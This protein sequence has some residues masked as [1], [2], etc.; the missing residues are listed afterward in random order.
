MQKQNEHQHAQLTVP[1]NKTC[2][3][4]LTYTI[5]LRLEQCIGQR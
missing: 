4:Y 1:W 5:P 3:L 2:R